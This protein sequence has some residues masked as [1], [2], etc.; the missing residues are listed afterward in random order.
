M[1]NIDS[2]QLAAAP[3]GVVLVDIRQPNEWRETGVIAGSHLLTFS[4]YNIDDWLAELEKLATPQ[5][6]LVL[7]CRSGRRTGILLEFLH[8]RTDYRRSRHL[9]DGILGW[10]GNGLAVE[11]VDG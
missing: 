7:V 2:K 9:T 6:D 11:T 4:G 10:L 3:G 1:H 8:E 5:D